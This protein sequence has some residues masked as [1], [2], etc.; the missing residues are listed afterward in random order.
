MRIYQLTGSGHWTLNHA[1]YT[2]YSTDVYRTEDAA[3]A[4]MPA[5][6]EYLTTP[7]SEE[8]QMVLEKKGLRIL[9]NILDLKNNKKKKKKD[10]I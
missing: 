5:F 10:E 6:A 1:R 3:R 9:I 4:A 2:A 7:K 8:D